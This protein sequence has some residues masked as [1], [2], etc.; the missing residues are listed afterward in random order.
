MRKRFVAAACSVPQC[1]RI[2]GGH[3][4]WIGTAVSPVEELSRAFQ[5]IAVRELS[6]LLQSLG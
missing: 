3:Q 1:P 6:A 2:I 5:K 4:R